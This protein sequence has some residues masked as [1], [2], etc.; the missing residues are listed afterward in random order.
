MTTTSS[1][2]Q[3]SPPLWVDRVGT[4]TYVGR[5]DRGAEVR[6]GPHTDDG[7]FSPGELLKIAL[8]AC[9][10]MSAERAVQRRLGPDTP[11]RV[12]V[13]SVP[14]PGQNRYARLLTEV[15]IPLEGLSPEDTELL[16]SVAKRAIDA[17]CTVGRTLEAN[18]HVEIAFS[19]AAVAVSS[20]S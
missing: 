6:L 10:G 20:E 7:V 3:P 8:A 14:G 18:A 15:V 9:S 19:D 17:G 1:E 2:P 4:K 5:N 12:G 11:I 13:R 16:V